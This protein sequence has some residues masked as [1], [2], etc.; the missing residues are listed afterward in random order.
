MLQRI[1][2]LGAVLGKKEQRNITGGAW[3]RT[4]QECLNCGGEWHAP[5]CALSHDS[6]CA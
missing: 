5:L 3:P 1:S 6:P 2:K 4:E